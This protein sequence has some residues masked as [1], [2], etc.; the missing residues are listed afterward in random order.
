[1][2]VSSGEVKLAR[3]SLRRAW[4]VGT[5]AVTCGRVLLWGQWAWEWVRSQAGAATRGNLF[6]WGVG[7]GLGT[8]AVTRAAPKTD[9]EKVENL[10]KG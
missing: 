10:E 5:G 6:V 4:G 1:M 3:G 8:V 7:A 2:T 9:L